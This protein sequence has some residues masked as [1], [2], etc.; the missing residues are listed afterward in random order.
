[1]T[2]NECTFLEVLDIFLLI[3]I[4]VPL[5]FHNKKITHFV[6]FCFFSFVVVVEGRREE[7]WRGE[8]REILVTKKKFWLVVW[9]VFGFGCVSVV[10]TRAWE[11]DGKEKRKRVMSKMTVYEAHKVSLESNS[12]SQTPQS[13]RI[14]LEPQRIKM[15][16]APPNSIQKACDEL[17]LYSV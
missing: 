11:R 7:R 14:C 8:V 10:C 4:L 9:F 17:N 1:M 12:N 3:K 2:L 5:F 13:L 6:G 16:A 15:K